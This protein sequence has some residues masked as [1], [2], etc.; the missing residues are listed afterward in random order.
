VSKVVLSLA[1]ISLALI[2]LSNL[3]SAQTPCTTL[4]AGTSEYCVSGGGN[5]LT[6]TMQGHQQLSALIPGEGY[7]IC[8]HTSGI[9]Y[10][11]YNA[12]GATSNWAGNGQQLSG[13]NPLVIFRKTD[14]GIWK[15]T[16][17]FTPNKDG[18]I[19]VKMELSNETAVSRKATL[20]RYG[21]VSID[22]TSSDYFVAT[23]VSAAAVDTADPVVSP[24]VQLLN[25]GKL[26]GIPLVQNVPD[27]P[28]PCS[29]DANNAG[30]FAVT[31]G[32]LELYYDQFTVPKNGVKTATLVYRPF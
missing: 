16:Q 19:K 8:D 14:D 1:V 30:P 31:D 20:V 15:L 11:D 17:T 5:I 2:A 12:G 32:S 10:F 26:A 25:A 22:G 29:P 23:S 6:M 28:H 9:E 27:G 3:A 13:P 18:S 21:N 7:G 24:G 4:S